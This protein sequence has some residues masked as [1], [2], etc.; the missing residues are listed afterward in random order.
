M[1]MQHPE[2]GPCCIFH[3]ILCSQSGSQVPQQQLCHFHEILLRYRNC[4]PS[5]V[6]LCDIITHCNN[7]LILASKFSISNTAPTATTQM[8]A[9]CNYTICWLTAVLECLS[10]R[11][12]LPYICVKLVLHGISQHNNSCYTGIFICHYNCKDL[13]IEGKALLPF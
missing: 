5:G 3:Q 11:A 12:L 7:I 6:W 2:C 8:S 13:H 4:S 9:L 10:E 1:I